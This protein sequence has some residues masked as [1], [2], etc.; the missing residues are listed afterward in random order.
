MMDHLVSW[1]I[2]FYEAMVFTCCGRS[3]PLP[4]YI[5]EG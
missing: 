1:L 2:Y 5:E 3:K 4:I